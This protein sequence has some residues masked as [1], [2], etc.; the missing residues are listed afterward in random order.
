MSWVISLV[1][2]IVQ[3]Q[4]L[5]SEADAQEAASKPGAAEACIA[6]LQDLLADLHAVNDADEAAGNALLEKTLMLGNS[7]LTVPGTSSSLD[8][9]ALNLTQSAKG[10]GKLTL[11]TLASALIS[12]H[13]SPSRRC[14]VPCTPE[15]VRQNAPMIELTMV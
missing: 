11:R 9:L 12:I 1:L 14:R 5:K 3:L 6:N 2:T 15:F 4:C 10:A 8:L 13:V 7:D